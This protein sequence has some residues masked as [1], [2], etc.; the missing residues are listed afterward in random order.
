MKY[1]TWSK[2]KNELLKRERGISFEEIAFHVDKGDVADV[3]EHPNER[4]YRGQRVFVV[5]VN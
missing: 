4:R 2:E 1:Y 5:I 3:L